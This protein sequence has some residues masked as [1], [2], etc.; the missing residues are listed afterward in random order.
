MTVFRLNPVF[1][2]GVIALALARPASAAQDVAGYVTEFERESPAVVYRSIDDTG[3][4]SYSTALPGDSVSVRKIAIEPGPA[5]ETI[6]HNRQRYDRIREVS[7]ELAKAREQRQAE[8]EEK[9]RKRL[10][11][12]ALQRSASP[13]VYERTVYV[14]WRP[15]WRHYP[16]GHYLKWPQR[17]QSASRQERGPLHSTPLHPRNW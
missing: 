14:G 16:G 3:R 11:W 6:E 7:L 10:E 4:V 8:R 2:A 13:P 12:L 1:V 17:P 15:L 5:D 9:E